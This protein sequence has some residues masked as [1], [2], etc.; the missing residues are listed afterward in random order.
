MKLFRYIVI[1]GFFSSVLITSSCN[2]SMKQEMPELKNKPVVNIKYTGEKVV[3]GL[4]VDLGKETSSKTR[5]LQMTRDGR[6]IKIDY[7]A[8]QNQPMNVY[9]ALR[10]NGMADD[11][12]T[13]FSI[14]AQIVK[15]NGVYKLKSEPTSVQMNSGSLDNGYY[16]QAMTFG[17][18]T[19]MSGTPASGGYTYDMN[20]S[21]AGF[22]DS[23]L[24]A[25][26]QLNI[27]IATKWTP[28][29]LKGVNN[30][31]IKN[32]SFEPVGTIVRLEGRN[33]LVKGIKLKKINVKSKGFTNSG[34]FK[35]GKVSPDNSIDTNA[36]IF[37]EP[38]APNSEGEYDFNFN[39]VEDF[40]DP[41]SFRSVRSGGDATTYIYVMP[42]LQTK[43]NVN[44]SYVFQL[45][46]DKVDQTTEAEIKS[47][48]A[49]SLPSGKVVTLKKLGMPESDLMITEFYHCNPSGWNYSMIEIY[50]PTC[51]DKDLKDYGLLRVRTV[52]DSG[53]G[54][55]PAD[56]SFKANGALLQQ[57]YI[58]PSVPFEGMRG[59]NAMGEPYGGTNP[60]SNYRVRYA[61]LG[62]TK[63]NAK[64]NSIL[65]PGQ[66]IVLCSERIMWIAYNGWSNDYDKLPDGNYHKFGNK[67]NENVANG[68]CKYVVAVT[69][70]AEHGRDFQSDYTS[71]TFTHGLK[72]IMV[73]SKHSKNDKGENTVDLIDATGPAF[74]YT[75][76]IDPNTG[77]Y[78][79]IEN[80]TGHAIQKTLYNA[81]LKT[82]ELGSYAGKDQRDDVDFIRLPNVMY[83]TLKFKYDY[84]D[85]HTT[86]WN[87]DPHREWDIYML[88]G[89]VNGGMNPILKTVEQKGPLHS[90][91]SR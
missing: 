55:H 91:G 53:P 57:L 48:P 12:V 41:N 15:D 62:G 88:E 34:V 24:I 43:N 29:D 32:L 31:T 65:K 50:N 72:Q 17:P 39:I 71:G 19:D 63:E 46:G 8:M 36:N 18:G 47:L 90:W 81:Y 56:D 13:Y 77:E 89:A 40:S 49:N 79:G 70:Y 83:P 16:I 35:L 7:E 11:K 20:S 14:K 52:G 23:S 60:L 68:N 54:V 67:I 45:D 51:E 25:I 74:D 1:A 66:T 6:L 28:I 10:K 30:F 82:F 75:Q 4:D 58:D 86:K 21:N 73:L 3:L 69:N 59:I 87:D 76:M 64:E 9:C 78:F 80:T 27:P 26:N 85:P 37:F 33:P 2:D 38:K 5:S 44:I 42:V 84:S 61:Y 22:D